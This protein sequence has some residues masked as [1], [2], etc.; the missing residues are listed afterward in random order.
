MEMI[1][2]IKVNVNSAVGSGLVFCIPIESKYFIFIERMQNTR[3]DNHIEG[4]LYD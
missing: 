1:I 3:P 2:K 4:I